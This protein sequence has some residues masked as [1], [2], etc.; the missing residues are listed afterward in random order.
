MCLD[1]TSTKDNNSTNGQNTS[2]K[3]SIIKSYTKV[4]PFPL[5]LYFL[6]DY[7]NLVDIL[8]EELSLLGE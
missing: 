6:V 2:T 8:P 7:I 5:F 3:V 1:P 4:K